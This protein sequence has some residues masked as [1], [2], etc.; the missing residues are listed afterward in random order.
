MCEGVPTPLHTIRL[1]GAWSATPS[2]D[3]VR[4]TRKFGW[5]TA[6]DPRERVWLVASGCRGLA[7]AT[8]NGS[9]LTV[10]QGSP[11]SF[12]VDIS[13]SLCRPLPHSA[14]SPWNCD[15]PVRLQAE[16]CCGWE[17]RSERIRILC[18]SGSRRELG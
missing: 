6:V 10:E 3:G 11:G 16:R 1:R 14:M 12:A 18:Q 13:A 15:P 5:P 2:E 17:A 4:Y 9:N 7:V 8:L